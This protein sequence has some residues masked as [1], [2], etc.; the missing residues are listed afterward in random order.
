MEMSICMLPYGEPCK[1]LQSFLVGIGCKLCCNLADPHWP[2][3]SDIWM[4]QTKPMLGSFL[5]LYK[6]CQTLFKLKRMKARVSKAFQHP[7]L[8][9]F[10]Q[11]EPKINTYQKKTVKAGVA[12]LSHATSAMKRFGLFEVYPKWAGSRGFSKAVFK[13]FKLNTQQGAR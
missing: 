13:T 12:K 7:I 9:L 8:T 11:H 5:S 4:S 2:I 10:E 6:C 1:F 3:K